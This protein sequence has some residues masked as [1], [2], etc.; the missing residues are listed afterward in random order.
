MKAFLTI[1]RVRC[2]YLFPLA[3][4]LMLPTVLSTLM[5][6][7]GHLLETYAHLLQSLAS[8]HEVLGRLSRDLKQKTDQLLS[9]GV[10]TSGLI[11]ILNQE[12]PD[13]LTAL[14]EFPAF[15]RLFP[16]GDPDVD[17]TDY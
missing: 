11:E 8:S 9:S 15:A 6:E 16:G 12:N 1:L 14:A 5:H 7:Y 10:D 13:F 2:Y 3:I 4:L 17:S